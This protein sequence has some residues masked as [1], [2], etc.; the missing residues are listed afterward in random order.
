MRAWR[1][2]QFGHFSERLEWTEVDDPTPDSNSAIIQVKAAGVMF[3]DLL[4][5]SGRYQFKAPLPFVPGSEAA[6][7]VLEAGPHSRFKPGDRVVTVNLSGAF[8]EKALA[9]DRGAFLIPDEMSFANAACFCINYQ[10]GYISLIRRARLCPGDTVL[11][12]AGSSGVGVAAIQLAKAHGAMV[13]ATAGNSEKLD[14]CR[15]AGAD[16]VLNYRDDD[17]VAAVKDLTGGRGADIIYDPVGGDVFDRSTRCLAPEGRIIVI[18]FASGRIPELA[19]N[20]L[21]LKNISLI[22][23]FLGSYTLNDIEYVREI[24]ETLYGLYRSGVVK[25]IIYREYAFDDLP[26]ALSAIESRT[27]WGKPVLVA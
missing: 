10:T 21:L 9:P 17:F 2:N 14:V 7:V 26:K 20:K 5:I 16:H 15:R 19:V 24:Q 3:A 18:G 25:P 13:I 1:V 4:S 23:F 6:G 22:G 12:H 11:V 27:C 8:A